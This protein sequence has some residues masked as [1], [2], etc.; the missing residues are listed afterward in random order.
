MSRT[1]PFW[2]SAV[3]LLRGATTRTGALPPSLQRPQDERAAT[4]LSQARP[5][6]EVV[7]AQLDEVVAGTEEAAFGVLGDALEADTEA[8][9]LVN[10]AQ[11]L[12]QR[13]AANV[14]RVQTATRTSANQV[15][16]MIT[17]V[18]ERYNAVLELVEDVRSLER[19]VQAIADISRSTTILAL[20][21]K[22]ESAR[23][24]NAGLGFAVVADEVKSLSKQS[25]AAAEDVRGGIARLTAV[26]AQ[27]LGDDSTSNRSSFGAINDQLQAIAADQREV[28]DLLNGAVADTQSAIEQIQVS[29][30]ALSHR[31]SAIVSRAQFQD[32]ARQSVGSVVTAL[33]GLDTQLNA[34]GAYLRNVEDVDALL[35][36]GDV[37]QDLAD[38]YVSHRQRAVHERLSSGR[39]S[40]AELVAGP[41]IELF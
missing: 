3:S 21:A 14:E 9:A 26:M 7:N 39:G 8:T 29:A 30:D 34:V 18:T 13:N 31:T 19:Y 41:A 20:N 16:S 33:S 38:S 15:E 5:L 25:S 24:G 17:L 10:L 27:R 6:L 40:A 2:S 32:I 36:T 11:D 22:V 28:A 37:V 23:A 1:R 4:V 35:A 12:A